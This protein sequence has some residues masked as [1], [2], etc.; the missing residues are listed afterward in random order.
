MLESRRRR[1][2]MHQTTAQ[3]GNWMIVLPSADLKGIKQFHSHI[4]SRDPSLKFSQ[5][6]LLKAREVSSLSYFRR[7]TQEHQWMYP[8][9]DVKTSGKDVGDNGQ[10]AGKLLAWSRASL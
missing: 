3:L 1:P 2:A 6:L 4:A 9:A 10:A 8:S 7:V 5:H